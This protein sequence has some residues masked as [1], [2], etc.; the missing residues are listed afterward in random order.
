MGYNDRNE[1]WFNELSGDVQELF[2]DHDPFD[3][4]GNF[5]NYAT[6]LQNDGELLY[7]TPRQVNLLAHMWSFTVQRGFESTGRAFDTDI[8]TN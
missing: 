4:L 8:A 2:T 3:Y 6:V 1:A 5:P 7:L